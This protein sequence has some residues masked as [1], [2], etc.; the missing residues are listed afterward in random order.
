L[1]SKDKKDVV[2]AAL[3]EMVESMRGMLRVMSSSTTVQ[4]LSSSCMEQS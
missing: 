3:I 2:E 1:S 4:R